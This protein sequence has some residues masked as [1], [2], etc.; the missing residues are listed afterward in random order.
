MNE[1]SECPSCKSKLIKH[2]DRLKCSVCMVV[3]LTYSIEDEEI[4]H[5]RSVGKSPS[6]VRYSREL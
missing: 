5:G 3:I 2:T 1:D 4:D 6:E